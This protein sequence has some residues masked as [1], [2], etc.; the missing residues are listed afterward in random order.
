MIVLPYKKIYQS[1]VLLM[2][3]SYGT[4]VLASD[5]EPMREIITDNE[6]GFLFPN[7]N[8]DELAD[9]IIKILADYD[10]KD[11]VAKNGLHLMEEKFDWARI[12]KET[13]DCY[14]TVLG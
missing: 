13:T 2:A 11:R 9:R 8:A 14:Q 5:L 12:G 6:T 1:G 4:A 7:N 3:M 10:L